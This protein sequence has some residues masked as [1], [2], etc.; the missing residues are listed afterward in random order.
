VQREKTAL[1]VSCAGGH[2]ERLLLNLTL[3]RMMY[4]VNFVLSPANRHEIL[5]EN[6]LSLQ[7]R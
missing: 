7:E 2:C 4:F 3:V 6:S 5:G 1:D